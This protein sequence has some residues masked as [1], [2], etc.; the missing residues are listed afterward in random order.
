MRL[1]LAAAAVLLARPAWGAE[2]AQM[3][4]ACRSNS[5]SVYAFYNRLPEDAK[6]RFDK[7][8]A[9]YAQMVQ[10][11]TAQGW[12]HGQTAVK[13]GG[14][15]GMN[16]GVGNQVTNWSRSFREFGVAALWKTSYSPASKALLE[17]KITGLETEFASA[18]PDRRRAILA[19]LTE[20]RRQANL[21]RGVCEDWA[22]ETSEV[23]K[24]A[25]GGDYEVAWRENRKG[26]HALTFVK[27]LGS[28]ACV[29]LDPWYRGLPE[30]VGCAEA[31][32]ISPSETPSCFAAYPPPS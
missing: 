19:Q 32:D 30:L 31:E 17:K 12:T 23:V 8:Y 21:P 9:A 16:L 2:P 14:V 10:K 18:S 5:S 27:H 6:P 13:V 11:R 1:L 3:L 24:D 26:G 20:V 15:T 4:I 28:G 29:A 25:A 22:K 7:V